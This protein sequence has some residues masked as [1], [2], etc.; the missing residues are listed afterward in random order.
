MEEIRLVNLCSVIYGFQQGAIKHLTGKIIV[1]L[2][3]AEDVN[4]MSIWDY[5]QIISPQDKRGE[6][7][8]MLGR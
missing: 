5:N 1:N 3:P 6:R 7:H 8:Q 2:V 4:L